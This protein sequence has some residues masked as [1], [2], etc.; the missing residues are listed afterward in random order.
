ML[1]NQESEK[2]PYQSYLKQVMFPAGTLPVANGAQSNTNQTLSYPWLH[3][4]TVSRF[5]NIFT[6]TRAFQNGCFHDLNSCS[7]VDKRPKFL[8]SCWGKMRCRQ[9]G[10]REWPWNCRT[11]YKWAQVYGGVRRCGKEGKSKDIWW[12]HERQQLK[13]LG[14]WERKRDYRETDCDR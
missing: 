10:G 1:A 13:G 6:L 9:E 4:N 5:L 8:E 3:I 14:N 2:Q 11:D 12:T 7:C